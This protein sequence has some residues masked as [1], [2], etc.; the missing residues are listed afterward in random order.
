MSNFYSELTSLINQIHPYIYNS[1]GIYGIWIVMHYGASHLYAE[2]CNNWSVTG[3]FY[4]PILNSTPYCKCLNWVIKTG[5]E[6]IDTMWVAIGTWASGYL[7]NKSI[8]K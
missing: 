2:T 8:F 7:L 5:S 3:F 4:S 6:T 1:I